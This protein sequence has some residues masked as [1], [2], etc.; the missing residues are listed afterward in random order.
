MTREAL[1]ALIGR[2]EVWALIFGA[3]VVIGVGGETFFGVRIWWNN[4]K[5]QQVQHS[6]DLRSQAEI[7]R[8]KKIA[9]DERLKTAELEATVAGRRL[10]ETQERAI[11]DSLRDFSGRNVFI[12]SYTGDAEAARLGLQIKHTLEFAKV[13]ADNNLGRTIAAEGGVDFGVIIS[14][15]KEDKDFMNAIAESLRAN[16]QIEA[17]SLVAAIPAAKIDNSVV[18]IMVALKPLSPEK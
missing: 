10:T 1:E 9:E 16:G 15:P 11:A 6:D 12:T 13:Q 14:G 8:L 3:L 7:E 2:L 4:R 17:R 5:L 18:G